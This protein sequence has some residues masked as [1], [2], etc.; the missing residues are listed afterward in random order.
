VGSEGKA[1]GGVWGE[2]PIKILPNLL[3]RGLMNNTIRLL[4]VI[5]DPIHHSLSPFMHNLAY[6]ELGMSDRQYL[7]FHVRAENLAAAVRG[8]QALGIEGFNATIPHKEQLVP[9]MDELDPMARL[10]GAVNTVVIQPDGGLIGYNTD[11][12]GFL[13]DLRGLFTEP[14]HDLEILVLGAG[15]AARGVLAALLQAGANRIGLMNRTHDRAVTLAQE[16]SRHFPD[17]RVMPIP[18]TRRLPA[19]RL[20]I[21]TTSLGMDASGETVP[22]LSGLP[23]AALVYD[24]V[25]APPLTPL[26]AAAQARGLLVENGLGMLIHQ[27]AKAFEIWTGQPMPV[28]AVRRGLK[29]QRG[30]VSLND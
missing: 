20:V 6:A 15:G 25:Y 9:L 10:I 29:E 11:G 4:G 8:M 7:P 2:A 28:A 3:H 14:L 5:G 13:T 23:E 19:S 16:F 24:I 17:R 18:W 22:D 30:V 12:Y 1:L 26:L 21:N 27:G